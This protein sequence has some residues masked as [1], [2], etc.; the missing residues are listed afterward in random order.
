MQGAQL[1]LFVYTAYKNDYP[2]SVQIDNIDSS[3]TI[4][5]HSFAQRLCGRAVK[6]KQNC[7]YSCLV[8]K[9]FFQQASQI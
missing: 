3:R 7:C 5:L 1:I 9:T 2:P 8:L 6:I 4:V